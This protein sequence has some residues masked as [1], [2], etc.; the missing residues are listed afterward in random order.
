MRRLKYFLLIF[1][2]N[3]VL[4]GG[5]LWTLI[6]K[7]DGQINFDWRVFSIIISFVFLD[8]I[9]SFFLAWMWDDFGKNYNK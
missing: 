5:G 9:G 1:L 4:V 7:F 3:T 8:S 6:Y 2:L